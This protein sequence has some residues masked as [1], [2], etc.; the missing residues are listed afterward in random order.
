MRRPLRQL[1]V[2][3]QVR[4]DS[5]SIVDVGAIDVD[6]PTVIVAAF[7]LTE[8][9][10][11]KLRVHSFLFISFL[12]FSRETGRRTFAITTYLFGVNDTVDLCCVFRARPR[13]LLTDASLFVRATICHMHSPL[14]CSFRRFNL[15]P[16]L[17]RRPSTGFTLHLVRLH[18]G[19]FVTI[20]PN[21]RP[22]DRKPLH[23]PRSFPKKKHNFQHFS[24]LPDPNDD[25][26]R[27][28]TN[29]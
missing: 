12:F 3:R 19:K 24:D 5:Q 22:T 16:S 27:H 4:V 25:R 15:H 28:E 6:R 20:F 17:R 1:R 21:L 23:A 9:C 11:S 10:K 14:Y 7:T 29:T 2:L 26:G 8:R 18:V 13:R